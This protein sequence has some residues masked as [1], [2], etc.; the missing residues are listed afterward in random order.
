MSRPRCSSETVGA[1][2]DAVNAPRRKGGSWG[3]RIRE[4]ARDRDR[5]RAALRA[6]ET[7]IETQAEAAALRRAGGPQ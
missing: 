6:A 7:F 4:L 5:L 3:W 2:L 1:L